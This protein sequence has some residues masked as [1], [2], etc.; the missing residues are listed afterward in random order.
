MSETLATFLT[1]IGVSQE[2][3]TKAE[4]LNR[5]GKSDELQTVLRTC[6]CGLIEE[7]HRVQKKVDTLDYLL[8]Q[9]QKGD[10]L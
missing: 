2:N 5:A 8:T 3:I 6:R 1:D 7:M 4:K 10:I 9:I